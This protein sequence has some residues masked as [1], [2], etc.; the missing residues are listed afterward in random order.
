MPIVCPIS[1]KFP[2]QNSPASTVT[3][4][5]DGALADEIAFLVGP[6]KEGKIKDKTMSPIPFTPKRYPDLHEVSDREIFTQNMQDMT[7]H[8]HK[9][10]RSK[11]ERATTTVIPNG[12]RR[13]NERGERSTGTKTTKTQKIFSPGSLPYNGPGNT[14]QPRHPTIPTRPFSSARLLSPRPSIPSTPTSRPSLN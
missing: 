9:P 5:H 10:K 14:R 6:H 12:T 4:Y 13:S 3:K 8:D 7:Q 2:K 1:R 11:R